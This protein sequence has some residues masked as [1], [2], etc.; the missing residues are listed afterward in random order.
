MGGAEFNE[1]F[2]HFVDIEW[3]ND[4]SEATA[5]LG[6][7][8]TPVPTARRLAAVEQAATP[9]PTA[10]AHDRRRRADRW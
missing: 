1:I 7:D 5:R 8:P 9:G 10:T 2:A 6:Y 4:W 3:R